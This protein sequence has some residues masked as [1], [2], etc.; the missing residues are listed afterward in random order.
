MFWFVS[1]VFTI[2]INS[3]LYQGLHNFYHWDV[4]AETSHIYFI[5]WHHQKSV[6]KHRIHESAKPYS[7]EAN[8]RVYQTSYPRE[9][10]PF[11]NRPSWRAPFIVGMYTWM[12]YVWWNLMNWQGHTQIAL[13]KSE[14]GANTWN[15]LLTSTGSCWLRYGRISC[16]YMSTLSST[17]EAPCLPVS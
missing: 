4:K 3:S 5:L 9:L 2:G 13:L 16:V 6:L 1:L 17:A 8:F 14:R 12:G 7:S 11:W 15:T 10:T